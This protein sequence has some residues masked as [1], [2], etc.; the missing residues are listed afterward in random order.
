M[1]SQEFQA[2]YNS[3]YDTGDRLLQ[4]LKEFRDVLGIQGN[5]SQGLQSSENEINK[6]DKHKN[7]K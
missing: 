5:E 2:A 4:Y 3:I 1:S 7:K 6:D